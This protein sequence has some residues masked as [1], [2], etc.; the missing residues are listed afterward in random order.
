DPLSVPDAPVGTP[1][2]FEEH[3]KLMFD[4]LTLAYQSE[5]TRVSTLMFA[6]DLSQASYPWSGNRGGFH[7]SSHHAN[8]K[9]RMDQFALI[10]KY[11]VQMLA[12]FIGKLA[13]TPDGDGT[14]LDHSMILYGSSMGHG[15]QQHRGPP[16]LRL[17]G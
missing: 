12:Y 14:L 9:E 15:H 10:N 5:T 2:A 8:V 4:L 1:E 17:L 13:A 7:G 16:P 6:K 11:H 3:V